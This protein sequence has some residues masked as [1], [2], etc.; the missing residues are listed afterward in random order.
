MVLRI[1]PGLN[2]YSI[3]KIYNYIYFKYYQ[4]FSK[5]NDEMPGFLAM[6]TMCWLLL[7]NSFTIFGL[8]VLYNNG[9][10]GGYTKIGG[11]IYALIIFI[12]H[13]T[14]YSSER[15]QKIYKVFIKE[16]RFSML[17]GSTGAAAYAFFT[18]WIF[19]KFIVPDIAGVMN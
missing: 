4:F 7:I 19:F 9:L 3:M 10:S 13:Q 5:I 18:F 2:K 6:M 12:V 14:Y 17:I 16:G 11:I 8:L 15:K 1:F